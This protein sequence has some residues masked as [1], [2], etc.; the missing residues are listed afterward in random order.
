MSIQNFK[1]YAS[2]NSSKIMRKQISKKNI[3]K[4]KKISSDK[5]NKREK[6]STAKNKILKE[7]SRSFKIIWQAVMNSFF[8]R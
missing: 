1:Q 8:N 4:Y 7:R 6:A 2:K 5:L 3:S